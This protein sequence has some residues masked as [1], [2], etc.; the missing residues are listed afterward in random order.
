MKCVRVLYHFPELVDRLFSS[1]L[2]NLSIY[3]FSI[4]LSIYLFI[5]IIIIIYSLSTIF[6]T[7]RGD[8][9]KHVI[10]RGR[11]GDSDGVQKII[12]HRRAICAI[13][14]TGK[15]LRHYM[16]TSN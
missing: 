12:Q 8:D 7:C 3:L 13:V 6:T 11:G 9:N 2:Y 16:S 5:I 14:R 4:Y 15:L 1:F 10:W